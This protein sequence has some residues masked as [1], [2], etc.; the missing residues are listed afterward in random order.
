[1]NLIN[2]PKMFENNTTKVIKDDYEATK[3]ALS[4]L[5]SCEKG[6]LYGDPFYGIR[7][8]RY[9]YEP[10]NYILRDILVDEIYTQVKTFCPQIYLP[11]QNI[12]ITQEEKTLKVHLNAIN[13]LDYTTNM[14][15]IEIFNSEGQ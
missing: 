10:N 9:F 15:D 1:M 6:E 7:L 5:L 11:R 2:F 14:Y 4:L 3:L 12:T 8:K 13:R